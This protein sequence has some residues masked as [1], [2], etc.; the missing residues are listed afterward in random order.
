MRI[1]FV[2]HDAG[3]KGGASISLLYLMLDMKA[4]YGVEPVLLT[5]WEGELPEKCRENNIEVIRAVYSFRTRNN[6]INILRNLRRYL[7]HVLHR[8]RELFR[9]LE[10]RK[11]DLVYTNT[12]VIEAGYHIARHSGIPHIWHIREYG[13]LDHGLS[14]ILPAPFIR[15]G[16]E[17]SDAVI[18]ISSSLY[19]YYVNRMKLCSPGNTRIIYNGI[20]ICEP[21]VKAGGEGCVN[22]CM[23][24]GIMP[25]KNQM[26]AVKACI[27]LLE[28]TDRFNLH[29]IGTGKGE[30]AENVKRLA[31]SSGLEGH[32]KFWGFRHDVNELLR[33]MDVGLMLSAHEAFGR[34]TVEYMNNYMPVIGTDTGATPE[35]IADSE[36]GYICP[37]N[38]TDRLA[39]LMDRFITNPQLIHD[40]GTKGR[41]RA[42]KHFP[43]ERNTDKIYELC[44]ELSPS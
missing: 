33:T 21:Y 11:F 17:R 42:V 34:V 43:L 5:G 14:C 10:G 19:N 38:D 13:T 39:E 44:C 8:N 31:V 32:V 35:I 4:R 12:S 28:K 1:L 22:F 20:K 36:T 15:K 9:P 30:Y 18:T 37:L 26:M 29:I 7:A 2:T 41:E 3:L 25:S 27:K 6:G 24:G 40:M 23:A 16:Y